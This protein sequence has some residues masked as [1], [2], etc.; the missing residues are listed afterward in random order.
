MKNNADIFK[1]NEFEIESFLTDELLLIKE[2]HC[3]NK[4]FNL[5]WPS[6]IANSLGIIYNLLGIGTVAYSVWVMKK[7]QAIRDLQDENKA[8]KM[9]AEEAEDIIRRICEMLNIPYPPISPA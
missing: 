8:I 3:R 1:E 2:N 9:S 4:R 7:N 6:I 5:D